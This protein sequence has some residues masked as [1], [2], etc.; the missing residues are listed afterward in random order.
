MSE[1]WNYFRTLVYN[2]ESKAA[3][4]RK[5]KLS[6]TIPDNLIRLE[7]NAAAVAPNPVQ[8]SSDY[9]AAGGG[10]STANNT[11]N[12][13]YNN[14]GMVA[15]V[16]TTS[17]QVSLHDQSASR[18]LLQQLV[19]NKMKFDT[20]V[21]TNDEYPST[22]ERKILLQKVNVV[23]NELQV[24]YP[25]LQW[26]QVGPA[27]TGDQMRQDDSYQFMMS[28]LP[29]LQDVPLHRRMAVRQKL[30]NVFMYEQDRN[31]SNNWNY[32]N[33]ANTVA[34]AT[35]ATTAVYQAPIPATRPPPP[36][37]NNYGQDFVYGTPQVPKSDVNV[38]QH[39]RQMQRTD[40]STAMYG[41]SGGS[42]YNLVSYASG[43]VN[44]QT[45]AAGVNLKSQLGYS[46]ESYVAGAV[47]SDQ[48]ATVGA[49]D[50][51]QQ[52]QQSSQQT[53]SNGYGLQNNII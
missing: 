37:Y 25:N 48:T 42:N 27:A 26:Q 21:T 9:L 16:V 38:R 7:E 47:V 50:L 35:T 33:S 52:M 30:Q 46:M 31:N 18:A 28:L 14:D 22:V 51:Q 11:G 34:T 10:S 24:K 5:T 15:T 41:K 3:K 40:Y 32:K 12:I 2:N 1:P 45:A 49:G 29:Y 17:S 13:N 43:V 20:L 23:T 36:P 19:N 53:W 8:V 39:N 4:K 44:D 6:N